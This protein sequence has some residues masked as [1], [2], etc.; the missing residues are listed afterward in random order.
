MNNYKNKII[1]ILNQIKP[2]KN[3]IIKP[4]D[5]LF[6]LGILDSFGMLS[7]I[8]SIETEFNIQIPTEELIPQNFWS[9][10]STIETV[11]KIKNE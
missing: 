10:E 6:A 4:S 8:T 7:Y 5:D 9:I 1:E 3:V 11:M 2:D